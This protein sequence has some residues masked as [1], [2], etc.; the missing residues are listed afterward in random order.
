MR[1]LIAGATGAIGRQLTQQ[2][3][4]AGHE[5]VGLA[6]SKGRA[7]DLESQGVR[8]VYGDALDRAWVMEAVR[9]TAPDALVHLLTAIPASPNP[10]RVDQEFALTNRLRTEG[11][12]NLVDAAAEAGVKRVVT[13]SIAFVNEP[14][15]GPADE[16]APFLSNPPKPYRPVLQAVVDLEQ[17]T[18]EAGGLVLRFGHLYGPGTGFAEDGSFVS[19]VRAGKVPVISGGNSVFS[20]THVADAASAIVTSLTAETNAPV[21]NVVDD[22]PAP[23]HVWLPELAR[24]LGAAKPKAAPAAL[25]RLAIG[26]WGVL[27][28]T[29]LRGA[30]NSRARSALAWQPSHTSWREGFAA[31][32]SGTAPA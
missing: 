18:K 10:K 16:D 5:V 23:V 19:Q 13:Q 15:Q 12:R 31:E 28:M 1:I 4:T 8:M 11:T 29:G 6:R 32:L 20:F 25:A 3:L 9:E 22:D 24:I 30:S 7:A 2:L 27:Y 14:G 17:I 26:G 21:L